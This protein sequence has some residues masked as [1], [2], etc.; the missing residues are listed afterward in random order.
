MGGGY[1]QPGFAASRSHSGRML[2][3][4]LTNDAFD[5][6]GSGNAKSQVNGLANGPLGAGA[7]AGS[8]AG[9]KNDPWS[10]GGWSQHTSP[11]SSRGTRGSTQIEDPFR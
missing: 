5:G 9:G 4:R 11:T 6:D 10:A 8:G 7:G 3:P 2:P 1:Q